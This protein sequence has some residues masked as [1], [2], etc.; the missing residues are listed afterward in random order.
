MKEF[1]LVELFLA[2][3][4]AEMKRYRVKTLEAKRGNHILGLSRPCED[5]HPYSC[6]TGNFFMHNKNVISR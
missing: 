2:F 6:V 4:T 5:N 3:Y 1:G